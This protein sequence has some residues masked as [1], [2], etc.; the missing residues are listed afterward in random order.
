MM[1]EYVIEISVGDKRR[2]RQQIGR[3]GK[4]GR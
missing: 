2:K 3:E 4:K 1:K